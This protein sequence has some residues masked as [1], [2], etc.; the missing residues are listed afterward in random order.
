MKTSTKIG[1]AAAGIVAATAV[2]IGARAFANRD[3]VREARAALT[4][5]GMPAPF[6]PATVA[7]LPAPAQRYLRHAIAP[8]TPL[9]RRARLLQRGRMKPSLDA[10]FVDLTATEVI[11]GGRGFVWEARVHL[12]PLPVAVTD[13]YANGVGE[14]QIAALG[15]VPLQT[16]AGPGVSRS[17]RGRLAG[18]TIWTPAALLPGPGVRWTA[19]DDTHAVVTLTVDGETIPLTL[20]IAADGAL[21]SITMQRYGDVDG[22]W[23]PLPYGFAVEAER[24]FGG[25]T[26]PAVVVGGWHFGTD[27][28]DPAAASRFEILDADYE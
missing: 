24:T 7:G 21:R 2:V 16:E 13:F 15:A 3:R 18:E 4:L 6:D 19:L 28:F 20:A 27:R 23:Q 8:G 14:V 11:V 25:F 9:V 22:P 5:P 12:G 10:A 26:I 17:S 1:W